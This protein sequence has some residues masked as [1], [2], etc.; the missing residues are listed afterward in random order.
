MAVV[1]S[2]N[3][4]V[5]RAIRAESGFS[6]ID[7]I[8]TTDSVAVSAPGPKGSGTGGLAGDVIGDTQHHG[9]DDQA[10]YAYAREDLDWWQAEL[11]HPLRSGMFGENLTTIG[12]DVTGPRIG[13]RW[14]IGNELVLQVTAPRIP[15]RD[16]CRVDE[17]QR[18]VEGLH[19]SRNSGG[20]STGRRAGQRQD[21]RSRRDPF[22]SR[23]MT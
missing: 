16:I 21:R 18:L 10:V 8:P 19:P 13:E 11:S 5:A 14:R 15:C 12:L 2:V 22:P 7:K 3:V 1:E 4:G 20:V 9:G 17:P 23:I 6:G